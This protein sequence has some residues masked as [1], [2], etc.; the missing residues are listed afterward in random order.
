MSTVGQGQQL[1]KHTG[2][3]EFIVLV[4]LITS[5]MALSTDAILPALLPIGQAFQLSDPN[6]GQWLISSIF[7]GFAA[8]GLVAGP[9]ADNF[10]R[11]PVAFVGGL[12]FVLGCALSMLTQSFEVLV[13]SRV[14]QGLGAS[15]PRIAVQ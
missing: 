14:L 3:S 5:L 11:R 15:G 12:V 1:P 7:A 2:E 13:F 9:L 6:Q 8:G 10:G 4:A